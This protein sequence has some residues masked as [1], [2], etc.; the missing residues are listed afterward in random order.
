MDAGASSPLLGSGFALGAAFLWAVAALLWNRLGREV[1]AAAMNLGKG[2]MALAFLAL[3]QAAVGLAPLSPRTWLVLG[4]SG[5]CGITLGDTLF[6]L[7]LAR[8][9]P[10]RSLLLNALIPVAASL[11]AMAFLHERLAARGWAG[12][13]LTLGGVTW[14]MRER[15]PE[16][17]DGG[18]W[19][20]G[21]GYG[22]G[23]VLCC[24][25]AVLLSKLGL[26]EAPPLQAS[27]VRLLVGTAGLVVVVSAQGGLRRQTL[28][29]REGRLF[30]VLAVASFFGTYLGI[31]FS[32]LAL[33]YTTVTL[34]VILTTTS[35]I[36]VLPLAAVFLGER[37]SARAVLGA[38]V[39]VGGVA[40]LMTG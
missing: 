14:V 5:L 21:I 6:F 2:V 15:E 39:A 13:A 12:A 29:L 30:A 36:F 32:L 7:S 28:P 18:S 16:A 38:A 19:R 31:W 9:G 20:A 26:A 25:V 40:L 4:L 22:L 37:I 11:L 8:L 23:S 33:R 24:A 1:S 27:F 3:T 35:P 34:Q 10:R 17:A